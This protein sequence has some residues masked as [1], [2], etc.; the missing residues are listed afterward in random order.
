[1]DLAIRALFADGARPE[2]DSIAPVNRFLRYPARTAPARGLARTAV[3]CDRRHPGAGP[4][5]HPTGR[6]RGRRDHI[7]SAAQTGSAS[8]PCGVRARHRALPEPGRYRPP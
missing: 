1:M 8:G 7:V 4:R 6:P 2:L 3:A 5:I